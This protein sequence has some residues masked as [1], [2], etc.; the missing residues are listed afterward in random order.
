[1]ARESLR[2]HVG[3]PSAYPSVSIVDAY[4]MSPAEKHKEEER[5][6]EDRKRRESG[7]VVTYYNPDQ[8]EWYSPKVW[9]AMQ[10]A[11][12]LRLTRSTIVIWSVPQLEKW[13]AVEIGFLARTMAF[14][15]AEPGEGWRIKRESKASRVLSYRIQ[16]PQNFD[17]E[18]QRRGWPFGVD[19][20][21]EWDD[22]SQL[23]VAKMPPRRE[24]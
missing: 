17:K 19:I 24:G 11:P 4:G 14:R 13:E 6:W 20:P 1:M 9:A 23:L 21:V 18:L 5:R 16:M 7:Q 12:A 2:N 10:R 3:I 15:R 8:F 22:K